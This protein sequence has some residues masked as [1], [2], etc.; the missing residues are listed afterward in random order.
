MRIIRLAGLVAAS[1]VVLLG[2]LIAIS[3]ARQYV[4]EMTTRAAETTSSTPAAPVTDLTGLN[5]FK[6][7]FNAA[8]GTPRLVMLFSPT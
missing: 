4:A 7:D 8:A 3:P 1:L 6:A 5:Q 2:G